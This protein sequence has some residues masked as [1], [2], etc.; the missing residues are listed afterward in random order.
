M[1]ECKSR[2]GALLIGLILLAASDLVRADE[3]QACCEF[4]GSCNDRTE[5]E[6]ANGGG[7]P[8][9]PGTACAGDSNSNGVDDACDTQACCGVG[10]TGCEDL[11]PA[12]CGGEGGGVPAGVGTACLGDNNEN[13]TDD[14]CEAGG[15]FDAYWLG[16]AGAYGAPASWDINDVPCNAADSY[17]VF[18]DI[19]GADVTLAGTSCAVQSLTLTADAAFNVTAASSY[20]IIA[21]AALH[22]NL[23]V[24][25][26]GFDSSNI[27]DVDN[28]SIVALGGSVSILGAT[29]YAR[30]ATADGDGD[31][32]AADA[33]LLDLAAISVITQSQVGAP[34][35]AA[36]RI[37]ST[38]DGTV[39]LSLVASITGGATQVVASGVGSE[40][41]LESLTSLVDTNSATQSY[42]QATQGSDINILNL[43]TLD[44]VD[45][46]LDGSG[47]ID[48]VQMT[49]YLNG[50]ATIT[51]GPAEFSGMLNVTGSTFDISTNALNL[52]SAANLTRTSLVLSGTSTA[53]LAAASNI[54]DLEILLDS[55][56]TVSLPMAAT[57]AHNAQ[58]NNDQRTL[59]A[60]AGGS[61]IFPN[62]T[63]I[64]QAQVGSPSGAALRLRAT[65]GGA[66]A[67][68]A[69]T[70]ITGG[71]T[72]VTASGA[73]SV[74]DLSSLAVWTDTNMGTASR[75]VANNG[76]SIDVSALASLTGVHVD[77]GA[78]SQVLLPQ[79][80]IIADGSL[81]SRGG[82]LGA[83]SLS[84]VDSNLTF[85]AAPPAP[86]ALQSR[87]VYSL[88]GD[89]PVDVALR[90]IADGADAATM[91]A[92]SGFANAGSIGLEPAAAAHA[93]LAL[94][95]GVLTNAPGGELTMAAGLGGGAA[96]V[97]EVN[98]QG[99]WSIATASA[100]ANVG[101]P[102]ANHVNTGMLTWNTSDSAPL[103]LTGS[104]FTNAAA[105]VITASG[106]VDLGALDFT[107]SGVLHIDGTTSVL[108]IAGDFGQSAGGAWEVELG[109]P[110][111]GIDHDQLLVTGELSLAGD[112]VV[113]LTGS[114]DPPA[115]TVFTIASAGSRQGAFDNPSLPALSGGRCMDLWYVDDDVRVVATVA[116]IAQ[117]PEDVA[118]C[119][120][121]T[122]SFSVT[123]ASVGDYTYQWR[124]GGVDIPGA[125]DA[126][127]V[128]DP[129]AMAD[130]GDYDVVVTNACGTQISATA[131]LTVA[132]PTTGDLNLDCV[133]DVQDVPPFVACLSGPGGDVP[134]GCDRA[135]LDSDGDVDLQDYG[136]LQVLTTN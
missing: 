129:V 104:S 131:T 73:L 55:G 115:G 7:T 56:A 19:P 95:S 23:T 71:A 47:T 116:G 9:G 58:G 126:T 68:G 80:A 70:S 103:T 127:L 125:T 43:A 67:L 38:N 119:A 101:R 13:G 51:G 124:K 122:A 117:Q 15:E 91:T 107:N 2:V 6:C 79:D 29:S 135:D 105:G 50:V 32:L 39:D 82:G 88:A 52:S 42:I 81:T 10:E 75:L 4:D 92:A 27:T 102:N 53:N 78:A 128:I 76:G 98:N 83:T 22:G 85:F 66:M 11:L 99:F 112:L 20:T 30:T 57:Y 46:F 133:A 109:G 134:A 64:T 21:G 69:L 14:A 33:G 65:A 136:S 111:P 16:G 44:G 45:L 17:N 72:Q 1:F 41:N 31:L 5:F 132:P 94:S 62:L 90:L 87:G 110:S 54:D 100:P 36:L 123:P 60:G 26:S 28:A 12:D 59:E 97:A 49:S 18:I 40:I 108:T 118:T 48:T 121:A 96:L 93:T 8:Q 3:T 130:Q 113:I 120:G 74:I 84:L 89:V 61:L 77:A 37:E 114:Y 86:L 35:N 34:Q 106:R 63:T 25:S 24:S